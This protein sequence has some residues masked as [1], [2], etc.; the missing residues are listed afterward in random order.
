MGINQL[1]E[2]GKPPVVE[3]AL[4]VQYEPIVGLGSPQIGRLWDQCFRKNF[5]KTEEHS[6]L[7]PTVEQF[8]VRGDLGPGVRI[9]MANRPPT[10]RF[11]FL[12]DAG[13]E[14]I[15]LQ[16]DRFGHNWRKVVGDVEYPRYDSIREQFKKEYSDF[17]KHLTREG[18]GELKPNQCDVTYVNHI[19]AGESGGLHSELASVLSLCKLEFSEEFLPQPEELRMNGCF[20]IPGDDKAPMGRLRFSIEPAFRRSDDMPLFLMNLVAR[21]CPTDD[22]IQGV[23]GFMDVGHEWIVR[24]FAAL[25]TPQMHSAWSR[26]R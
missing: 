8:G 13:S 14:L 17:E 15:Q 20:V 12:N 1:P 7:D 2:F 11:W 26:T 3:V 22:G 25:T 19:T 9:E 6:P 23:L 16:P 4:S 18:L 21:G 10:P 24:G 5:S